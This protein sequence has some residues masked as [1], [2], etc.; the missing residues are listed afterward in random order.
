MDT[1]MS[2]D[3][4]ILCG[5]LCGIDYTALATAYNYPIIKTKHKTIWS[6]TALTAEFHLSYLENSDVQKDLKK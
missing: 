1:T 4:G 5:I 2:I 3:C 6:T